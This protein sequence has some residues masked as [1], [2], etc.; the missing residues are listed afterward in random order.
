MGKSTF[1]LFLLMCC[2]KK[3]EEEKSFFC[4]KENKTFHG[5]MEVEHEG[6]FRRGIY[7]RASSSL[8]IK[9]KREATEIKL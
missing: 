7:Q 1:I 3:Q 2:R 8:L 5:I 6:S 4:M 9:A